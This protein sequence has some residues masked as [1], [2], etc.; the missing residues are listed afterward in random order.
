MLMSEDYS[1]YS[2]ELCTKALRSVPGLGPMLNESQLFKQVA[3]GSPS[4]SHWCSG[5]CIG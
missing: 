2:V 1:A 3:Y 5:A 4:E